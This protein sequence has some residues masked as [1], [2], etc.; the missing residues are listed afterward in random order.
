MNLNDESFPVTD[1]ET[2]RGQLPVEWKNIPPN[3]NVTHIVVYKP[4]K[5]G[6]FNFTAASITYIPNEGA[7]V[8]VDLFSYDIYTYL[9]L[10]QILN[11]YFQSNCLK[12]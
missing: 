9:L 6:Y 8:Q 11:S 4:L 7:D 2:I 1:F 12:Q 10:Q 3:G 5:S